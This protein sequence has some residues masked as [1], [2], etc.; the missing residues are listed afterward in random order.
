LESISETNGL[1]RWKR[2]E[3]KAERLSAKE[4]AQKVHDIEQKLLNDGDPEEFLHE[5]A[6]A[7]HN[8]GHGREVGSGGRAF[9]CEY[10]AN[11]AAKTTAL[12]RQAALIY[13]YTVQSGTRPR[14]WEI[15][16]SVT[17]AV[18]LLKI[19]AETG[20]LD[21]VSWPLCVTGCMMGCE[22]DEDREARIWLSKTLEGLIRHAPNTAKL[23]DIWSAIR[24]GWRV[25]DGAGASES[26]IL[27]LMN[28]LG[29]DVSEII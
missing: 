9:R 1:A 10:H 2:S 20:L 15:K 17:E 22:T 16:A 27:E 24:K 13:V 14:V 25:L 5:R 8:L 28:E 19:C 21:Y 23:L 12:F 18:R 6:P 4:L 7:C 26:N 29:V 3:V 11:L